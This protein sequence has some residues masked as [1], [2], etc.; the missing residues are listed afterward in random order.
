MPFGPDRRSRLSPSSAVSE[1]SPSTSSGERICEG[2]ELVICAAL[3]LGYLLG[4]IPFGLLLARWRRARATSARSARAIS[5]R[6]TCCAPAASGSRRRPC[7][8]I[9][10]RASSRCARVALF[11]P[12]TAVPLAALGAVIGHCF[13]VWLKFKG[14]KGVA[15]NSGVSLGLALADRAGLRGRCGSACWRSPGSV[16]SA[17]MSAVIA[18]AIACVVARLHRVRCP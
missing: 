14:G 4:S 3:A 6:P 10:A 12:G 8:S 9:A 11:A 5:A 1:S 18:A 16:R 17:G 13:P 2:D 15:T 7:C